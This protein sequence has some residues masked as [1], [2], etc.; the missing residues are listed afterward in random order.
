[1]DYSLLNS[2]ILNDPMN[3]GYYISG[4]RQ[5]DSIILSIINDPTKSNT[6]TSQPLVP[7]SSILT[8]AAS[9]QL[10]SKLKAGTLVTQPIG[11]ICSAALIML[12]GAIQS[13]DVSDS[14][15]KTMLSVLNG[16]GVLTN[17][18][19]NAIL[20][21]GLIKISRARFLLGQDVSQEDLWRVRP[22]PIYLERPCTYINSLKFEITNDPDNL[23]YS[24]KT[25]QQI[26]D[27][28]NSLVVV[29]VTQRI[30]GAPNIVSL[31]DVIT[32]MN[33]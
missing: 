10:I 30:P 28:I 29:R 16:A 22:T 9:N 32:A 6:T 31:S 27:I 15:H 18:D 17:D 20:N 26:V 21:L 13:F 23:G 5:S 7:V 2:E 11:D 8:L 3:I 25:S 1:M 19:V 33:S 4:S 12:N 14:V 24:T